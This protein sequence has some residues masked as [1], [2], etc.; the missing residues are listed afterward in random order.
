MQSGTRC[1]KKKRRPVFE[2]NRRPRQEFCLIA[3][4]KN[5]EANKQLLLVAWQHV[6]ATRPQGTCGVTIRYTVY[7]WK[8]IALF[9]LAV[10]VTG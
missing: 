5:V 7:T 8:V 4:G 2:K 10:A 9:P 3:A 1:L 6:V